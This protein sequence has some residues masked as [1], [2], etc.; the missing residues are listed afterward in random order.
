[1]KK[2]NKKRIKNIKKSFQNFN[3]MHIAVQELLAFSLKARPAKMMLGEASSRKKMV[4]GNRVFN[5]NSPK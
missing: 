3:Q 1:M 4:V 5:I 2:E